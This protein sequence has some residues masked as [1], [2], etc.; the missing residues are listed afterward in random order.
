M[1]AREIMGGGGGGGVISKSDGGDFG[2]E[3][4]E[5][6]GGSIFLGGVLL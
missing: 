3:G 4:E 6:P 1:N 5:N 2:V